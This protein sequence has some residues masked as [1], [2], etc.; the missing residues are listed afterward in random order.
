VRIAPQEIHTADIEAFKIIH[1]VGS[2]WD[3]GLFYQGQIPSQTTDET[4][5]VFGIRNNKAAFPRRRLFQSAGTKKVVV[6]WEPEVQELTALAVQKIKRDL[7][8]FGSSDVMKWWTLM[9]S[10][11]TGSLAFGGSFDNT[12]NEQKNR[13]IHDVEMLLPIIGLRAEMPWTKLFMDYLPAW[14]PGSLKPFFRRYKSYGEN[15]VQATR[16]AQEDNKKT[17]F[18]KMV[19][20]EESEQTIPDSIIEREAANF[21]VAGTDTTT[22]T[23]TYLVYA[24]LSNPH[25]KQ[26]LVE[27]IQSCT[28][29]PNWEELEGKTYLNNVIQETMRLHPAVPGSLTRLVPPGRENALK[30]VLPVGTEIGTQAW[31]FQRDPNVFEEPLRYV[32]LCS[33]SLT[34]V[35]IDMLNPQQ[36]QSRSLA[37]CNACDEGAHDAVRGAGKDMCRAEHCTLDHSACYLEA[38]SRVSGHQAVGQ[39]DRRKYADGGLFCYQAKGREMCNRA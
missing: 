27:E 11:V 17:V 2:D 16:M 14:C 1:R 29:N 32:D 30:Y 12:K 33:S 9:S 19:L 36:I 24:V 4:A 8:D 35:D 37:K 22:M 31:T 10:D 5:G 39:Y 34:L 23:L 20:E 38:F 6:G 28:A 15:A 26:K 21:I 18:S 3:K 25:I 7:H 13:L